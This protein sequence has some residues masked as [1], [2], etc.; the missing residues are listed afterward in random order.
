[1]FKGSQRDMLRMIEE[2]RDFIRGRNDMIEGINSRIK[3]LYE[4]RELYKITDYYDHAIDRENTL[5]D[6]INRDLSMHTAFLEELEKSY[7]KL[8]MSN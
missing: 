3:E 7:N 6:K 4:R 2:E 1:M 5:L 8:Y